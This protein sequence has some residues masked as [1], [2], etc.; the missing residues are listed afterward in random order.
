MQYHC[1]RH[2]KNIFPA[3]RSPRALDRVAWKVA[4]NFAAELA[5][6]T[7]MLV[8]KLSRAFV[9][10]AELHEARQMIRMFALDDLRHLSESAMTRWRRVNS[11]SLIAALE[12][13]CNPSPK[14]QAWNPG[15]P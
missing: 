11:A 12:A 10:A 7:G 8:M 4:A 2:C 15:D 5:T 9:V 13:G 3:T 1:Q 6:P 14:F